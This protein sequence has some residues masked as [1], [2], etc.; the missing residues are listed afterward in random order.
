MDSAPDIANIV[1][2]WLRQFAVYPATQPTLQPVSVFR[3]I[4]APDNLS[5]VVPAL[6]ALAAEALARD[7][8][9]WIV[10]ADDSLL[11]DISNALDL[12]LR[13][14]CLVLPG[15][16]YAGSIALRATL[17]LLKSRLTRAAEDSEGPAWSAMRNRL[18]VDD[19]LWRACL[20]WSARG[21]DREAPPAAIGNLF[22]VRIGPW[23][24]AGRLAAPADWVMLIQTG[25]LPDAVRTPW[26]EARCTLMLASGLV[27]GVTSLVAVDETV[28]L[29]AE[30]EVL[31]QELAEMELEFATAQGEVA[32]F[33]ERYHEL[34][35]GRMTE[36]DRLHADLAQIKMQHNPNDPALDVAARQA[37]A[38]AEQTRRES[39]AYSKH[40]TGGEHA[41]EKCFKPSNDLKKRFRQLA[42]KIHP[43][44]ACNEADRAWRTQLMSEANRAYRAGDTRGL[45]EVFSLWREG[46]HGNCSTLS[47]AAPSAPISARV[48]AL[49]A[50][51]TRIRQRLVAITTELDRLYGSKL[52]ELFAA[53][54]VAARQGR[55][56]LQEMAQRLDGQI[57]QANHEL[58][59][60]EPV[61]G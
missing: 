26:P 32:G 46:Q 8:T 29:R 59:R 3:E 37:A 30:I 48:D 9:L 41:P 22:P 60:L 49:T 25:E 50:E 23:V 7:R 20:A 40:A 35:A 4:G 6:A 56:L 47:D 61:A 16:D 58:D 52:Y 33:A 1:D 13:P 12:H 51:V 38:R 39:A 10:T 15:A 28:R 21:L 17:A 53:A 36:L 55:D 27:S 24:L 44:R 54:R 43:D 31:G 34:I 5:L 14:L 57:A 11:P 19:A 42:Q 18:R 45:E 2:G